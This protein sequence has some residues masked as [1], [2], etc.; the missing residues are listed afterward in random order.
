MGFRLPLRRDVSVTKSTVFVREARKVRE[1]RES[2]FK[3]AIS[4]VPVKRR[5]RLLWLRVRTVEGPYPPVRTP[6]PMWV[7]VAVPI[8]AGVN[9]V[10]DKEDGTYCLEGPKEVMLMLAMMLR[11]YVDESVLPDLDEEITEFLREKLGREYTF[12]DPFEFK[13]HK[14]RLIAIADSEPI[15]LGGYVV[16]VYVDPDCEN[17]GEYDYD[18]EREGYEVVDLPKEYVERLGC[19]RARAYRLSKNSIVVICEYRDE[20]GLISCEEHLWVRKRR[21]K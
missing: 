16:T 5:C 3:V 12:I 1:G 4:A 2:R 19:W 14:V 13:E 15:D 7:V 18:A 21:R 8:D 17:A 20:S 9:I 10:K 6:Y 11:N